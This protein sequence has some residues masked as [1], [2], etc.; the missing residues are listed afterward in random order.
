[1]KQNND[2]FKV[3][4][5][6]LVL[7]SLALNAP[8]QFYVHV[9][10]YFRIIWSA[11]GAS[12]LSTRECAAESLRAALELTATRKGRS[13]LQWLDGVWQEALRV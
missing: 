12:K 4:A 2:E 5:A 11:L 1:M 9:S 13:R 7:R 10:D 3:Q 6:V 8:S